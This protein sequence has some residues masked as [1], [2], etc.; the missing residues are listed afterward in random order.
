MITNHLSGCFYFAKEQEHCPILWNRL[1]FCRMGMNCMDDDIRVAS[2]YRKLVDTG[3]KKYV[4]DIVPNID[5]SFLCRGENIKTGEKTDWI[6]I[7]DRINPAFTFGEFLR[8]NY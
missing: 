3:Y 4:C 8:I 7:T 1:V 2:I 6:E 5:G